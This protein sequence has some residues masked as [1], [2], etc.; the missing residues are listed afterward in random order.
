MFAA[1]QTQMY[2]SFLGHIEKQNI[3]VKKTALWIACAT[4][5]TIWGTFYFIIWQHWLV[6]VKIAIVKW[7]F[8]RVKPGLFLYILVLFKH[9]FY[10]KTV[11]FSGI[12]TLIDRVE[13]E[14]TDHLTTTTALNN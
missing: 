10:I 14:H 6:K 9:K 13:G 1:K 12:W 5:G 7:V 4:F 2:M 11:G 3:L 8:T